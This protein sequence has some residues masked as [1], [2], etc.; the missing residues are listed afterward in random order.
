M[1]VPAD[2]CR[3][4][5]KWSSNMSGMTGH[6]IKAFVSCFSFVVFAGFL[7]PE[8]EVLWNYLVVSSRILSLH[9]L[10]QKDID[11][12]IPVHVHFV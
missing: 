6:Q 10:S 8:Q 9:L 1:R 11:T 5:N 4:L 3:L 12:V 7:T 2:V